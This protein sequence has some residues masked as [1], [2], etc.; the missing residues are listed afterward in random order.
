MIN[1]IRGSIDQYLFQ[2]YQNRIKLMKK[3]IKIS[4]KNEIKRFEIP[5][6][7]KSLIEVIKK[8]FKQFKHDSDNFNSRV[9]VRLISHSERVIVLV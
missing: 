9:R 3:E 4:L 7:Y 2:K 8:C 1:F 6:T 5:P